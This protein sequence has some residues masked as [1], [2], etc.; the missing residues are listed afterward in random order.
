V[1]AVRVDGPSAVAGD[2]GRLVD[3]SRRDD[4]E[5]LGRAV[6]AANAESQFARLPI[7]GKRTAADLESVQ[8]AV[9]RG[10]W[11]LDHAN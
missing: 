3:A 2:A 4:G 5:V 1:R 8:G 6:A 11:L 9:C 7:S 10:C